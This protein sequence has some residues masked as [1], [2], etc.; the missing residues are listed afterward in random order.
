MS[1]IIALLGLV[2]AGRLIL[3][4]YNPQA[5]LFF[6]GI[7]LMAISIF[8]NNASFVAKSTGWVGFD[9]FEYISQVFSKQ[10]GGLGLNIMLIGGFALF[11]SAIGASQVMVKVAAKPL[12]K[13]N[14]PYLML[15]LAFILGQALSLFISSA[16][17]LALLLMATLYPV[18]IRLGCSKAGVAA[19]LASTCAIEF[20]PASGNSILAAQTA[21]M[22][23]TAF[24]VGEQLP[25]VTVLIIAVALI[26]A[27]TQRYFDKLD[28]KSNA[29]QDSLANV[30]DAQSDAPMFYLLLPMLPLFF[31]LT[32]SKLGIESIKVS[33]SNAILLSIFIGLVCEFVRVKQAKPVFDKLQGI[34]NDMGKVFA[35]VVTLI[36]AGQTFSMGLKSIG[37]I[38]AMLEMASGA[39]L[40]AAIIILFMA[41][42]TFTISA[43][44]G[45]GN[46][47]FFS[48]A[49][50]VPQIA[51]KIGANA[52]DMI[53]PI[54]LS[55][56]MGRTISPIAGV[57]IAVAG[58]SGLSP[59]DIVRR[60]FIPMFIGWLLM[61]AMTFARGGQLMQLLPF[62]VLMLA[63]VGVGAWL[64]RKRKAAQPEQASA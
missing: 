5:V 45:S 47:A 58:I 26:H 52:A 55:A 32:F 34:F 16:T 44:M 28:A 11:M 57:I 4:N 62:L 22:D 9:I 38:D 42:L 33:L 37:A 46:A 53:L 61:L 18:L 35:A 50:M 31:M 27:L 6:T 8:T 43:L 59:F 63:A 14:S 3:K 51:Q 49:P 15:A 56:G 17:G 40:S 24:F 39:G 21:G 10:S 7:V 54:Q 29:E 30:D 25:I 36:V 48:F 2:F 41:I 64:L 13:L 60:T 12:M 19:V 20:G 23:I 1:L